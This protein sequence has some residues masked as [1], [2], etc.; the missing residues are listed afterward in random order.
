[1]RAMLS[2]AILAV[3]ISP[4]S[5]DSAPPDRL[6]AAKLTV[7]AF[8]PLTN[9]Q[10]HIDVS[11][12]AGIAGGLAV[13]GAAAF[14]QGIAHLAPAPDLP[15]GPFT[16]VGYTAEGTPCPGWWTAYGVVDGDAPPNDF[17]AVTQGQVK[18]LVHAA[19]L[20]LA[21]TEPELTW[22]DAPPLPCGADIVA[23]LGSF[24]PSNNALPVTR[25]QLKVAVRPFW[26]WREWYWW[27]NELS[28]LGCLDPWTF[29]YPE[30]FALV[31]VGQV[32]NAFS[33]ELPPPWMPFPDSDADGVPDGYEKFLYGTDMCRWDT[34]G[35]GISD[36]EEIARGLNPRARDT[37]GDGY[38][39]GTDPD[40][41]AVTPWTDADGDG[42]PDAWR[43]FWF[44]T[45][46]AVSASDDANTNGISNLASLLMGVN[47]VV[48]PTPGFA[49]ECGDAS[50]WL[51]A[52]EIA[53]SAFSIARPP[54]LTNLVTR[55]LRVD[56]ASP[57][58][59][60]FVSARAIGAEGWGASDV[61]IRYGVDGGPVTN[62][63][64]A[65]AADS[66]RIP[67]GSGP[68]TNL[69]FVIEATGAA[70]SLSRPLHVIRWSPQVELA[71]DEAGRFLPM[72]DGKAPLFL[73]RRRAESGW[74]VVPFTTSL[75]WLPHLGEIDAEMDA[76]LALPPVP[77]LS[78]TNG[79]ERAFLARDPV[80]AELPP[81]GEA[82]VVRVCCW[83]LEQE[84]PGAI[85]SGPR[86]SQFDS[87]YPLTSPALRK[88]FHRA[89]EISADPS[90]PVTVRILPRHP[91]VGLR[92]GGASA[93]LLRSLNSSTNDA[94]GEVDVYP[95]D[96]VTPEFDGVPDPDDAYSVDVVDSPDE[97]VEKT[98]CEDD[99]VGCHEPDPEKGDCDCAGG[100]DGS[101][102]SSFRLRISLGSPT[103][104]EV[105][106]FVWTSLDEP[107][108]VT[109]AVFHVLGTDAVTATTNALGEFTVICSAPAGR[110][111]QVTNIVHGVALTVWNAS[112]RLE[113][114][115][116]VTN[117]DGDAQYV[118]CRK[119]TISGNAVSDETFALDDWMLLCSECGPDGSRV[120]DMFPDEVVT[121]TDE[122]R[123]VT[124]VKRKWRMDPVEPDFVTDVH[125]ESWMNGT[126]ASSVMSEFEKVGVGSQARR[127]LARRYGYDER[128]PFSEEMAYWC[129]PE[130]PYRHAR[131]KSVRSDRRPWSF[132]DYDAQGRE[133][134]LLEQLDG[135]PFPEDLADVSHLAEL[136]QSCSAK[137]T[138]TSYEPQE[139]DSRDRNDAFLPRRRETWVM[140]AGK[141][142]VLV[143]AETWLYTRAVGADGLPR[144][145][146]VHASD[147]DDALRTETTVAYPEDYS[148]P[149]ELRGRTVSRTEADG[150]TETSTVE[151]GTWD[152]GA[153]AFTPGAGG[154]YLRTTTRRAGGGVE[155]NT[156]DVSV[157]DALRRLTVFRATCLTS[158]DAVVAFEESA[159]DDID[160]LRSTTYHDG[161]SLTNAYSC[162]RLLWTR[163]RQN[164]KTLRSAQTGTDHLY[165]AYEEIWIT[166]LTGRAAILAAPGTTGVPPVECYR[167]TQHFYDALGRETNTVTYAGT[168]P[169]EAAV[170]LGEAALLPLQGGTR[171][172]ASATTTYTGGAL[173]G[174]EYSIHTDERGAETWTWINHYDTHE[175]TLE[176]TLTNGMYCS[177]VE[178]TTLRNGATTT[179]RSWY[180]P[181]GSYVWTEE[182]R[183]TEYAPN[184]YR[185][186]YVVTTSSDHP[187]V[188]NSISTYDLLGRLVTT[189]TPI[190]EAALSPLQSGPA[191]LVTSN[192]YDG[193]TSRILTTTRYAP[194]LEP[195][196]TIYLYN[197][198]G[199][200]VGTVL[201]NITNRTDTTYETDASNIVWR[202]ETSTVVGPSTNSL[203]ITRTQL[204][205]LSDSCRRHTITISGAQG[206]TPIGEAALSPL[207]I[208]TT[209]D[210]LTTY[211]P[212]TGIETETIT[213]S[214][215]PTIVRR[216]LHGI[217]L[218]TEA[219]GET[220]FNSYDAFARV[221]ATSRT[222]Y[223]PVQEG[224]PIGEAA[225]SP[226][227]SYDYS[228]TGDLLAT[229]TY[230][231]DTDI[232]T[233]TYAYDMLGKR[234]ATTDAHGSTTYRT[235]DP[236]GNLTAEWG[237]TYPVRYTYDTQGHRTSLTTFRT[238]G[239]TQFIASADLGD[240]TT[241]TY[242]PFT[243][244]CLSK[245]YA[246]GSTITYTYTPDNLPLRTTYAS[247]KWKENVYDEQRRLSGVIYSSPD[248]NYELQLDAYGRTVWES[249]SVCS[250]SYALADAG[251]ATNEVVSIGDETM[252]IAR[253]LDGQNRLLGL[254][255]PD[256]GYKA[257]Y[258]YANDGNIEN[259]SNDLACVSYL[260]S[261]N[262]LDVGYSIRLANGTTIQRNLYRDDFRRSLVTNITTVVNG[263]SVES[264]NYSFDAA[265]RPIAR[266]DDTFG[267][268][269]RSEVVS[270]TI[271]G[272]SETHAYDDIGNSLRA[273][274][275]AVTNTFVANNLNQYTAISRNTLLHRETSH[276]IDGNMTQ[277]GDWTYAYDAGHRLKSVSSNGVLLVTNYY[278]AKSR[279]V[280]KVMP[281]ATITFFYDDWNLIEERISYANGTASLIRY[282]WGKDLSG[283]LQGV[284]G[285]GGLLYLMVDDA[286]YIPCY[287]NNGNVTRYL[288][289]NGNTVAQYTYDAFGNTI[290]KSGPLAD[291]FRHRFS[292]KYFDGETGLHYFDYRFYSPLLMRWFNRDPMEEDGGV[293]LYCFVE[294]AP[295][296]SYDAFGMRRSNLIGIVLDGLCEDAYN[297]AKR[298][299]H[300]PQELRAWDRYT[301]HGWRGRSNDIE[302]TPD[303]VKAIAESVNAVT[304]YV[305]EKR[306]SCKKGI[307]FSVST[308]IGGAAPSPWVKAL[309]GV[310]IQVST[311]CNDGCF[312]YVY[313][314]NDLYD[315]DIKGLSGF[316]SRGWAGQLGTIGVNW[317]ETCLK[318]DWQTFYHKGAYSSK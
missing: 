101:S 292:T 44:G 77:G 100:E 49:S 279:R 32:K 124:T 244:N 88:A 114:R 9:E 313:D 202:V 228:P 127:R 260:Y 11:A 7:R 295:P 177:S 16:N 175:R 314:I 57:W 120:A 4:A 176:E 216:S 147:A 3:V 82:P 17:A 5:G 2:L 30:D 170:P 294:N 213:S 261:S 246:D 302:L 185:I 318:C 222:G 58:Q 205:G 18:W 284:G 39:D 8:E 113:N 305:Q 263:N 267:Y 108:V 50:E 234:I 285:I 300:T 103:P 174:Y 24:S 93:R 159:Y 206:G 53:P 268:N 173:Y 203:T 105:A 308:S 150:V 219:S 111:V 269:A 236:L 191:W 265:G 275:N 204:T 254:T 106:G 118:R 35:D 241:W 85:G 167:V 19:A 188:T 55:T 116:E 83:E 139:G 179:R 217:L 266:N 145:T 312:S 224:P 22:G 165:N 81:E 36:G 27:V 10:A 47:P 282:Y 71:E 155:R 125:D 171:S 160:R 146:C 37:D 89:R 289:A 12:S 20:S 70:P 69:T 121:R 26:E 74:Y 163:D 96:T 134:V 14:P 137:A 273:T 218:S 45:N 199:E 95:P 97:G 43:D 184:G 310:S 290:S 87:P 41:L 214:S 304:A 212:A 211:D 299:L 215:G 80:W 315:F 102:L 306:S 245:T 25:G 140:R 274:F 98:P 168:T 183:F 92:V 238:T 281:D 208:G 272:N 307:K 40:P 296:F 129:D 287:D 271:G 291:F 13:A 123:G 144:R 136:P 253:A 298:F 278:D 28:G 48:S 187:A 232:L 180:N 288:D 151:K 301:K 196:T 141:A 23:L 201:D 182:R 138:V 277:C 104:G 223:Q 194:T 190:G 131:L 255:I 86:A 46:A 76:E 239:G 195:R 158:G 1:M 133:T 317:T 122:L 60:L 264:L 240:T 233:E 91:L 152:G 42:F 250:I 119:L 198:W 256:S 66:W 230:T 243:G 65:A 220:T 162:C 164:R 34:D 172:C 84:T 186:D 79:S 54:G 130:N 316:K 225:L 251:T 67:L 283:T 248:M 247:G 197:P 257:N 166:N 107:T 117:P 73:A 303:E 226:L 311:S 31:N 75:E 64:P 192:A 252:F 193:A 207:Q 115:W 94:P 51:V 200:Q 210:S 99:G 72:D 142:P 262:R 6:D 61:S 143:G 249:N 237:A 33:F 161:T 78:I 52:W 154:A 135:S 38:A 128:G 169:G 112:G 181:D 309:G 235:Y 227:Q 132:H 63:V 258:A 178:R 209:T 276:D 21:E 293:N 229:H 189:A 242:D 126:C 286:I 156:Y 148:V 231:N 157:E 68:V 280:R 29:D 56:R 270:A 90:S 149:K 59:Q 62:W 259:I 153:R 109:P 297:F 110:I 221:V 15:M